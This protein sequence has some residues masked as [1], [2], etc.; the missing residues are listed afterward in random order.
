MCPKRGELLRKELNIFTFQDLLTFYPFRYVDRSKYYKI[1]EISPD[2]PY[3][4]VKG[5][6]ISMETA[7][8]GRAKRL[9]ALFRDDTGVIELIWFQGARWI[10]SS[11]K[12]GIEYVVFGKP[13]VFRGKISISHPEMDLVSEENQKL[14]SSLQAVYSSTEK[15]SSRGLNSRGVAKLQQMLIQ[16]IEG[17]LPETLSNDL[18]SKL[19]L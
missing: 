5:K 1:N 10:M 19:N 13:N 16:Q 9:K 3:I 6:I 18:I 8:T 11:L 14:T 2:L 4:Q 17:K 12:T 7:G 15:L